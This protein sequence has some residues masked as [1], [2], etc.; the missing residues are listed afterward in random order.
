MLV[1]TMLRLFLRPLFLRRQSRPLTWEQV[2]EYWK[3]EA[4]ETL[5]RNITRERVS[6]ERR[7]LRP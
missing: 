7:R 2:L 1:V 4:A 3:A 6:P 5:R